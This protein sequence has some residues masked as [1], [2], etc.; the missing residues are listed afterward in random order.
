MRDMQT[1]GVLGFRV[2]GLQTAERRGGMEKRKYI[3]GKDTGT[4]PAAQL[5][6]IGPKMDRSQVPLAHPQGLKTR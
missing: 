3:E 4:R 6:G 5:A 1:N 2:H